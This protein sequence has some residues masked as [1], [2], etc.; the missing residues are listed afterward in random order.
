MD[1]YKYKVTVGMPVYGVE[2]YIR[3]CMLSVLNQTFKDDIEILAI[4]DLGPDKSIDIIKEQKE[5][6]KYAGVYVVENMPAEYAPSWEM[7]DESRK[8]E[9]VRSSRMY[10]FT[11]NGVLESFWANI[12]FNKKDTE[13]VNINENNNDVI[14]NYH[15]NI[16]SQMMRLR[17]H[18]N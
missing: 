18:S 5:Q 15:Q 1:S 6:S 12:D 10:D 14:G 13:N 9:I 11:K 3:K 16:L 8:D 4:D 7:L 2:K 17:R